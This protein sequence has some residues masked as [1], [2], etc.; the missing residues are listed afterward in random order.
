MTLCFMVTPESAFLNSLKGLPGY[1]EDTLTFDLQ[2]K[3]P[4]L[5]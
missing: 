1:L 3:T 2:S 4:L 5:S